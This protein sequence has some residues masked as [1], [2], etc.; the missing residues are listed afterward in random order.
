MNEQVLLID[1]SRDI[2]PLVKAILSEEPVDVSSATDAKYGLTLAASVRPD[3]ILLDVDM[4]GMDGFEVCKQIKSNPAT[5]ACPIIFLTAHSQSNEKVHGF[6]LGAVDYV[7]KPFNPSELVARVR[8]SLRTRHA[9]RSLEEQALTDPLSGLGNRAM[10]ERRLE[11]EIAV[12][13]R[14]HG[15]LSIIMLD[16]DHFKKINDI[17]GHLVGDKVLQRIGKIIAELCRVEDVPCRFGGDEF[18]IIATRTGAGD[19]ER[20]AERIRTMIADLRME[21]DDIP[22][23]SLLRDDIHVTASFGIADAKDDP[24]DRSMLERADL[25]LYNAKQGGR[26][27]V[28]REPATALPARISA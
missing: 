20:L 27:R 8:S 19:A 21:G 5:A 9:I 18:A 3:L 24:Y 23:N 14:F 17:Q 26:N 6:A 2:H 4:P 16:V 22:A 25:A 15:P 7:T 1:D 13:I 12:R 10:F 11:A 28:S